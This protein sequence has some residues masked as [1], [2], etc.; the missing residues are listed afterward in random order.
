MHTYQSVYLYPYFAII[1][2]FLQCLL[3]AVSSSASSS[4]WKL[5]SSRLCFL[6]DPTEHSMR[7][8]R[9][10]K[11]L[12]RR[13]VYLSTVGKHTRRFMWHGQKNDTQPYARKRTV[14][15]L[16]L[17]ELSEIGVMNTKVYLRYDFVFT[18]TTTGRTFGGYTGALPSRYL[19]SLRQ[20]PW[21][22]VRQQWW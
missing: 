11:Q 16:T 20:L 22:A 9:K 1:F 17:S 7:W 10:I 19:Q 12:M 21:I 18:F 8:V 15:M 5:R 14:S 6:V 3:A 2:S 13:N 4:S